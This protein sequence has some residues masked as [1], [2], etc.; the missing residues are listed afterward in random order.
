ML[1]FQINRRL[2]HFAH[3]PRCGGTA[4]ETYLKECC[5][6]VRFLDWGYDERPPEER[7]V[8]SSPQHAVEGRTSLANIGGHNSYEQKLAYKKRAVSASVRPTISDRRWI[9]THYAED[10]ERFGYDAALSSG[11]SARRAGKE[12]P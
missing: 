7:L 5:G 1:I 8:R 3:V 9:A 10:F 4:G 6:P 11:T 2:Y 12:T